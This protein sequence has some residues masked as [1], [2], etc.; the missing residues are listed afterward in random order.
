MSRSILSAAAVSIAILLVAG[1]GGGGATQ[2]SPAG[3]FTVSASP[4]SLT[5]E[6]GSSQVITVSAAESNNFTS[7]ISVATNGLPAGVNASP[8]SFSVTPGN[9]VQIAISASQTVQPGTTTITFQATSGSLTHSAVVSLTLNTLVRGE[10]SPF[11]TRYLRTNAYY[12]PDSMQYAPPH[13]STYD[14]AHK[15]FFVSNPYMNEIDAFDATQEI[16][17]AQI[18]VP[19]AWG[20]DI[21][22]Y[23]GNLYAGTLIGDVYQIDTGQFSLIK[24]YPS[25]SI[26]PNGYVAT[27]AFVMSDGRLALMGAQGGIL[28]VDGASGAAV[29]DPVA[30]TLDTNACGL[31]G[32]GAFA[33]SGDR[34]LVLGTTVDSGASIPLCSYDP[35]AKTM[36]TGN[37]PTPTGGAATLIVPTPDGKRFFLIGGPYGVAVFDAKTVQLLGQTTTPPFSTA[38]VNGVLGAVVSLDGKTLYV[39]DVSVSSVVAL[40]TDSLVRTGWAP[41]FDVS[42]LQESATAGAID[43]T[44]LIVGPTGHGVGFVDVSQLRS[45]EPTYVTPGVT[46]TT[47][48]PEGGGTVTSEFAFWN[49][50]STATLSQVFVGDT[51]GTNISSVLNPSFGYGPQATTPSSA[52]A[53][54]V[55]L[56]LMLSDGAIGIAP[57]GF[58]YGPTI[59]EVVPN[60]ATAEGGQTGTLIGYGFG[61]SATGVQLTVGGKTAP[62]TAIVPHP[63]LSPYPFPVDA[64]QFTIPAGTA[65]STV[66]VTLTAD[67]GTT[68]ATAAFHYTAPADYY[69]L[70]ASLQAGIYD[71]HRDLY[72]FTDTAQIRVLSRSAGK[73]LSPI[74]L[75]G[76]VGATRLLAIAESPDGSK[77]AVSDTGGNAI[78]LL[79]PDHPAA[80]KRFPMPNMYMFTTTLTPTGLAVTNDGMIYFE[81]DDP[82]ESSFHKLDTSI[83]VTKSLGNLPEGATTAG[84]TRILLSPDGS[85]V[86][87]NITDVGFRVNTA[88]DQVESAQ[89]FQLQEG[90]GF[91][92]ELSVSGDGSTTSVDGYITDPTL[93]IETV[94]AYI[95]WEA[96]FAAGVNGQKL[97]RDG[98]ILFQPLSD[99]VDLIAR[100]TGRLLYRIQIPGTIAAVYDPLVIGAGRNILAAIT[101]TGVYIADLSSLPVDAKYTQPFPESSESRIGDPSTIK[102]NPPFRTPARKILPIKRMSSSKY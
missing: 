11:R 97:N 43:E 19:M 66:D 99:G 34:R 46:T 32:L 15:R 21:S 68:T 96:W 80:A 62:I 48:G 29:W 1:C 16:E 87:G 51:T 88:T 64:L 10:Y 30:N 49:T 95:D 40:D 50:S 61:T 70:N 56:T 82:L 41:S 100:N 52:Q 54:P 5:L 89:A 65:G 55:D 24:R 45:V 72:Y 71:A 59:L 17:I 60:G 98:S 93:G 102:P 101:A 39:V 25:A 18:P 81:A 94:P 3:D 28:G 36:T 53:G 84:S 57:E 78:Y 69:P 92:P 83:G 67:S 73:W 79:D 23:N 42:D 13:F 9:Q 33:V 91:F 47:S 26:G 76:V 22:P 63:I 58:S 44:G 37:M 38:A 35:I 85:Q 12:D 2:R 8:A 14:P 31:G 90:A 74:N 75:P 4:S 27:E 86:Y 20:I 7:S 77:V 6:S